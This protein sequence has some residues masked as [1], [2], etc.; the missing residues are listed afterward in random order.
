[1]RGSL[2]GITQPV[3]LDLFG[4]GGGA[5]EGYRRA[6]FR[7][8][9]VDLADHSRALGRLGIEFHQLDWRDALGRFGRLADVIHASPPCQHYS[10]ASRC[11]PGLAAKYPDL[12]GPVREALKAWGGP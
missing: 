6:G 11:R 10:I 5:A 2:M 12:I 3:L 4:G 1:M 8:I 9:S 7:V